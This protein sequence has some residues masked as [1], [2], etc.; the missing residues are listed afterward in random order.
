[1]QCCQINYFPVLQ[2]TGVLEEDAAKYKQVNKVYYTSKSAI[3]LYFHFKQ[4]RKTEFETRQCSKENKE[5]RHL[6]K[7]TVLQPGK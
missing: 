3:Y 2:Q 5:K 7:C 1:M 4:S 6:K